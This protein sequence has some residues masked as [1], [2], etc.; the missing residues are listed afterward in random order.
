MC[1]LGLPLQET[2]HDPPIPHLYVY[3][4]E[5]LMMYSSKGSSRMSIAAIGRETLV[6]KGH[7]QSMMISQIRFY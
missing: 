2:A 4:A 1:G 7:L 3:V 5:M 6:G